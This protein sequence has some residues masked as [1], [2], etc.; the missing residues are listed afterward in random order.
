MQCLFLQAQ[1]QAADGYR[2]IWYSL[3]QFSAY[4]DKYSGGLGTYTADHTPTAAYV[5]EVEKTFFLYGGTPKAEERHLQICIGSFE[6][7][8][9]S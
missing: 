2:G 9:A 6:I 5:S 4:G 7:G 1:S 8:R 3:G